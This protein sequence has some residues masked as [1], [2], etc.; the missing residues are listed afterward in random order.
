MSTCCGCDVLEEKE[1]DH[2]KPSYH[3]YKLSEQAAAKPEEHWFGSQR[4][5]K[6]HPIVTVTV[7]A[8]HAASGEPSRSIHAPAISVK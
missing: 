5:L 8:F 7:G 3:T 4:R 2:R 6:Y 1:K